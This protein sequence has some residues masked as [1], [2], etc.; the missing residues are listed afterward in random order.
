MK[1]YYLR[2]DIKEKLRIK[3]KKKLELIENLN[4]AFVEV[5]EKMEKLN[6]KE[7]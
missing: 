6:K 7:D 1:I 2:K 4:N 5:K 3:N